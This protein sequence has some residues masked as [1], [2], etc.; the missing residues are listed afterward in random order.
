MDRKA[1]ADAGLISWSLLGVQEED[2]EAGN[3]PSASGSGIDSAA[4]RITSDCEKG[5]ESALDKGVHVMVSKYYAVPGLVKAFKLQDGSPQ[6]S[7]YVS[8]LDVLALTCA[9]SGYLPGWGSNSVMA[10]G[11]A[12]GLIHLFKSHYFSTLT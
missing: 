4:K 1:Y 12:L 8:T 11:S 7:Q 9:T 3:A 5:Y 6:S 10:Y 2:F